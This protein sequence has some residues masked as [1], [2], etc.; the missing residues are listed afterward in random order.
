MSLWPLDRTGDDLCLG[1]VDGAGDDLFLESVDGTGDDFFLGLGESARVPPISHIL[2]NPFSSLC[3]RAM[4]KDKGSKDEGL[5]TTATE[6]GVTTG[7][8]WLRLGLGLA[9]A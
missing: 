4:S 1:S 9:I 2:P 8:L 7:D 6:F 3:G 5:T